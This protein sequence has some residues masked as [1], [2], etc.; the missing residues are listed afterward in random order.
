MR[1]TNCIVAGL[2]ALTLAGCGSD[3]QEPV[4]QIV[5]REPGQDP[6]DDLAVAAGGAG[7]NLDLVA[8]G[9]AG[10]AAC[11]ACHSVEAGGPS[12]IGPNLHGVAGRVAGAVEGYAYSDA[13]AS[14]GITWTAGELDAFIANPAGKVPGTKMSAGAV[15]DGER[16]AAIVAYLSSLQS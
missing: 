10:F 8:A 13:L 1:K 14:S 16:R 4:E 12:G 7:A 2:I 11:S 6:A 3:V 15:R 9:E 5:V